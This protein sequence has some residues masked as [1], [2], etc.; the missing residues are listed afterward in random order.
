MSIQNLSDE[1]LLGLIGDD[2]P[3]IQNNQAQENNIESLSDEELL[4]LIGK[5]NNQI[6]KP[7]DDSL[8]TQLSRGAEKG[9]GNLAI[10][11]VQLATDI[12]EKAAQLIE[13]LYYGDNI[14]AQTFG[15]RL[16]KQVDQRKEE[17]STLPTAEKIGVFVGENAPL[18]T[19]GVGTGAKVAAKTGSKV[20]GSIVGGGVG[21][22]TQGA[23]RM[24]G[25]DENRLK[26]VEKEALISAAGAGALSAAAKGINAAKGSA[27]N[28]GKNII[29]GFKSK[30]VE[31]LADIGNSI[32][33]K[34]R[35]LY[36]K[37]DESGAVLQPK[38]TDKLFKNVASA[39]QDGGTLFKTNHPKT[40]GI[41]NDIQQDLQSK[42]GSITLGQLDS[43][44]KALSNAAQDAVNNIGKSTDDGRRLKLAIKAIDDF[45]DKTDSSKIFK[46]GANPQIVD[47]YREAQG[48]WKKYSKFEQISNL[49][50]KADGDPNRLKTLVKNFAD[51][52]KKT[53][54]FAPQ[55]IKALKEASRNSTGEGLLKALGKFGFDIGSGRNI[56]NTIAPVGSIALGA[57]SL[58][59]AGTVARKAQKLAASGKIQEVL[60]LI[61]GMEPKAAKK[62]INNLPAKTKEVI[63]SNLLNS[64]IS[65]TQNQ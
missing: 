40:I 14:N 65:N 46:K 60:N 30:S 61:Q 20:I 16:K 28:L 26:E 56:G 31:E 50:K 9:L 13:K 23:T 4:G 58:A 64:A 19:A 1:E 49:I 55:E 48:E 35:A 27:L 53:L 25:E 12:G 29:G 37:V 32:A 57:P 2:Q 3:K 52:N 36:Q 5:K 34:S 45:V 21:G 18:L 22:A 15:D 47:T 51:N 43:Y 38:I 39:A 44:R 63:F 33:Q 6:Q 10:G 42:G 54:G 7:E 8:S 11:G 62:V 41:L 24:L 17:Q 59:V